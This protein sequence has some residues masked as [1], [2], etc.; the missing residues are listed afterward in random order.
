[1]FRTNDKV[2]TLFRTATKKLY[3]LDKEAKNNTLSSGTSQYKS[4]KGVPPGGDFPQ[5][6]WFCIDRHVVSAPINSKLHHPPPGILRAFDY[7]PC[8]GS[9]GF[10]AKFLGVGNLK[11]KREVLNGFV[12][13]PHNANFAVSC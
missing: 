12:V 2:H 8:K 6:W 4:C 7:F 3:T 1:M 10:D 9:R 11:R 5:G 13:R